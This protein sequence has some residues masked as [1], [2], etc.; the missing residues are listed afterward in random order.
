MC[1]QDHTQRFVG[2]GVRRRGGRRHLSERG[3]QGGLYRCCRRGQRPVA[4]PAVAAALAVAA[5]PCGRAPR[6]WVRE[7][8]A[9]RNGRRRGPPRASQVDTH[10]HRDGAHGCGC[11]LARHAPQRRLPRVDCGGRVAG[12]GGRVAGG[13]RGSGEGGGDEVGSGVCSVLA[14]LTRSCAQVGRA[15][16]ARAL[17]PTYS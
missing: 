7:P 3:G 16:L 12:V 5:P 14:R 13:G 6:R 1:V 2:R 9:H 4:V 8:P 17:G 10:H 11:A 15:R